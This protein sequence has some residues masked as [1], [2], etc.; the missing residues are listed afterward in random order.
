MILLRILPALALALFFVVSASAQ[1]NAT[2]VAV[3]PP[4]RLT[5]TV[6]GEWATAGNLQGWTGANVT[7]L[8]ATGGAL[9]GSDASG[10]ND[11]AVSLTALASGPDLD[12]G[13]NDYL[14][15]RI[16]VPAAY[17]GAVRVEFGTSTANDFAATRQF[18]IPAA[19][20]IP[21]K[22]NNQK[23][24]IFSRGNATSGAPIWRGMM[25]FA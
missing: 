3:D 15:I 7:G 8:A 19:T 14:Q 17:T 16:K 23:P 9:V 10:S 5:G 22:K 11:A 20:V 2:V 12:L 18:V 13:F 21:P 4:D 24:S 25:T 1:Q 6:L